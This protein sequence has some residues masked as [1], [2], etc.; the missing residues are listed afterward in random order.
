VRPQ[1]A[2]AGDLARML[3]ALEREHEIPTLLRL[4]RLIELER[5]LSH[6]LSRSRDLGIDL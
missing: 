6:D 3:G 1:V 2:S 4:R 5:E